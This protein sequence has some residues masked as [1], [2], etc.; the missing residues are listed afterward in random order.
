MEET[1]G[2]VAAEQ[3]V[4]L[5]YLHGVNASA[6]VDGCRECQLDLASHMEIFN[7]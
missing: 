3:S 5:T 4:M 1:S 7:R 2:S 6:E